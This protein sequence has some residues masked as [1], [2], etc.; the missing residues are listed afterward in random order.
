M[1]KRSVHFF[2]LRLKKSRAHET[3]HSWGLQEGPATR[4]VDN[5]SLTVLFQWYELLDGLDDVTCVFVLQMLDYRLFG[6]CIALEL[7]LGLVQPLDLALLLNCKRPQLAIV[8]RHDI[9]LLHSN[10]FLSSAK[11]S[12]RVLTVVSEANCPIS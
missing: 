9:R 5:F 3:N 4:S 12:G 8:H 1:R 7:H 6:F 11:S 2:H 10:F